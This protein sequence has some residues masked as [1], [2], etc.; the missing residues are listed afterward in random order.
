MDLSDEQL[1]RYA[2]HIILKEIGGAGQARLLESR[3]A[4]IGAGG[5]G[6]PVIQYL[7]AAGGGRL[8]I[9][10]DDD[11]S[12]SNLQRQVLRSEESRVGKECVS[13]CRSG[14]APYPLKKKIHT[15][16]N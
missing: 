8:T 11:V 13:K 12:L 15:S 9:I 7:A 6:S 4:V 10:D 1:S 2:R 16:D 5:I 3:V 14:W